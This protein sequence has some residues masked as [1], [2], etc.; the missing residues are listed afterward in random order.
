MTR[1]ALLLVILGMPWWRL[2]TRAAPATPT[3][4]A[5]NGAE[6]PGEIPVSMTLRNL[7]ASDDV[8]LAATT[9]VADQV[10][11]HA[12]HLVSGVRQ[13]TP[14]PHGITIPA[15]ATVG[16]E[17]GHA[18][19]MLVGLRQDLHQGDTFPLTLRFADAG[20]V[21]ITVRVRRK[22]DAAGLTP[23]PPVAIGDLTISLVSAP[24]AAALAQTTPRTS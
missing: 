21:T 4:A 7:G 12:S 6:T 22:L 13:M 14:A 17:P 2:P 1:R 3:P 10:S 8:L 15:G 5:D 20:E 24:P 23:I 11:L 19:L 16:M 9:P 18:H